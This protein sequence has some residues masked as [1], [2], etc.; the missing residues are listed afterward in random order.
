MSLFSG[1]RAS[2]PYLHALLNLAARLDGLLCPLIL[3]D[4]CHLLHVIIIGGFRFKA[5]SAAPFRPHFSYRSFLNIVQHA[6]LLNLDEAPP[7]LASFLSPNVPK[8]NQSLCF[9]ITV[10]G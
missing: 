7:L 9:N 6:F 1:F 3:L 2:P 4:A 8:I 10:Y 5:T